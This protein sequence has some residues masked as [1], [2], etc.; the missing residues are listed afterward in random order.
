LNYIN[1]FLITRVCV[2]IFQFNFLHFKFSNTFL[3]CSAYQ[4][5]GKRS[6]DAE[7]APEA[8]ADPKADPQWWGYSGYGWPY[9]RG[10]SYSLIGKRSADSEPDASAD[11][12]ADAQFWP[13][14]G[15]PYYG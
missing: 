4:F 2:D 3:H 8:N 12:K 5:I 13:Y 6:A 15:Y 9:Y 7:P 14:Y 11:S 10:Y 1:T